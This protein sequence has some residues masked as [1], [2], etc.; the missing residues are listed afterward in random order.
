MAK[1]TVSILSSFV[2]MAMCT[3]IVACCDT[4]IKIDTPLYVRRHDVDKK[5]NWRLILEHAHQLRTTLLI[6]VLPN[7]NDLGN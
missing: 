4:S 6:G 5:I 1:A 7:T 3:G 2:E